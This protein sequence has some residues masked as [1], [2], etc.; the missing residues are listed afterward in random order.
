MAPVI[1]KRSHANLVLDLHLDT[2]VGKWPKEFQRI[3]S[4]AF[5]TAYLHKP[6]GVVYKVDGCSGQWS[7]TNKAEV[8]NAR[9]LAKFAWE[10]VVIPKA[11]LFTFKGKGLGGCDAY[12]V[13]MEYVEGPL[14]RDSKQ[15][16]SHPGWEEFRE[17]CKARNHI[18]GDMHGGNFIIR[19]SDN[20]MV[21]VDLAS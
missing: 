6:T 16:Y 7:Y 20:K 11:S 19:T 15:G 10:H 4:G 1:G 2:F 13:A 5:R 3:G 14:G 21:P 12:V 17:F 18:V 9:M 8:R